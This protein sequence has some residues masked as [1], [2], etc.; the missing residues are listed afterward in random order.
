MGTT[1]MILIAQDYSEEDDLA[2]IK[3]IEPGV[4]DPALHPC[5]RDGPC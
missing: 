5:M 3:D 2:F 4:R 1:R